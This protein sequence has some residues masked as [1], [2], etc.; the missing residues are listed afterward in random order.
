MER[1]SDADDQQKKSYG[2]RAQSAGLAIARCLEA[3]ETDLT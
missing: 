1:Q 2:S 3:D